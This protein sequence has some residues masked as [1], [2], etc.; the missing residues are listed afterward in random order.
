MKKLTSRETVLELL[1]TYQDVTCPLNS[2]GDWIS[3][4]PGSR[5]HYRDPF[6]HPYYEGSY[7]SLE[8][9]L[10]FMSAGGGLEGEAR[11]ELAKAH[12]A[13]MQSFIICERRM[14]ERKVQRK[15]KNNR[16]VTVTERFT[17]PVRNGAVRQEEL[18]AGVDWITAEF[19]RRKVS[20]FLPEEV[21]K[22]VAA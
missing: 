11:F 17:E 22:A 4:G 12:W 5:M 9:I 18:D 13:V 1:R 20:P 15:A 21:W 19:S 10:R 16:T 8:E 6:K 7:R 2:A 14:V 3:G